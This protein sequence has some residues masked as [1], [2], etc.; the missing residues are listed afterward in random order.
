MISFNNHWVD[1]LFVFLPVIAITC[2]FM[3]SLLKALYG[4]FNFMISIE[5]RVAEL[6]NAQANIDAVNNELVNRLNELTARANELSARL[7]VF[8]VQ[9]QAETV[10]ASELLEKLSQKGSELGFSV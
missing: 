6:K 4:T 10:D 9:P 1:V 3:N 2:I 5:N 7:D 8:Q